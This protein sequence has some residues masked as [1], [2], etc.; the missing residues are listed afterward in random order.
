[1]PLYVADYLADTTHLTLEEHGAYLLLIMHYW[2]AGGIPND[3]AEI[4]MICR[5]TLKRWLG[6]RPKIARLFGEGWQHKRIDAELALAEEKHRRRA[7][8]GKVGGKAKAKA[9]Q[10]PSNATVLP[11]QCSANHNHNHKEDSVASATGADAPFTGAPVLPGRSANFE[12]DVERVKDRQQ[13]SASPAPVVPL[14]IDPLP[15]PSVAERELFQRGRQILG[16]SA[17]GVINDLLRCR[18]G[19]VALA[20]AALEEASQKETPMEWVQGVIRRADKPNGKH[21]TI[22][23]TADALV[24]WVR[25]RE[26]R[27]AGMSGEG[28][29][30]TGKV[31]A[32]AI[33][34][35]G[36][37]AG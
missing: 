15:D 1:M 24:E 31:P 20:R 35:S 37:E 32:L 26:L 11:E 33:P 4:A 14:P 17:G 16:K 21:L 2:R 13:R 5:V 28:G 27:D 7:E 23:E 3:D 22:N 12:D 8:A 36:L 19:N 18:G 25:A 30:G 6:L 9:K 10:N 29:V 34:G